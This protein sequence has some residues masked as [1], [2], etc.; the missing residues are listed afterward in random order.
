MMDANLKKFIDAINSDV[1][2][3]IEEMLSEAEDKRT[4][5]LKNAETEALNEQYIRIR[6]AV[7]E[8]ERKEKM[9]VS[10]IDPVNNYNQMTD[11]INVLN[12]RAIPHIFYYFTL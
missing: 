1:D 4:D 3:Q 6:S 7:T 12:R 8:A 10:K 5:I 9:T 11:R 2:R